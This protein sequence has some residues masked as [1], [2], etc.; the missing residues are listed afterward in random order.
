MV[1]TADGNA[2]EAGPR[3]SLRHARF[4]EMPFSAVDARE[5]KARGFLHAVWPDAE[6][7]SHAMHLAERIARLAPQAARL[8]KQT[9]RRLRAY[10]P[11]AR[12]SAADLAAAYAY[13]PG[14]EHR[15]GVSAF[16]DKRQ[17]RF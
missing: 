17:P 15:E 8:N 13:A 10:H 1:D 14:D 9:L 3:A 11:V 5:M 4:C 2:R 7:A 6:V 16:L 12:W